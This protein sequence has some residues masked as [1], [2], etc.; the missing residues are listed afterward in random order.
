LYDIGH[1]HGPHKYSDLSVPIFKDTTL[2]LETQNTKLTPFCIK[3]DASFQAPDTICYEQ[4]V[5]PI[6]VD[7]GAA[8]KHTWHLK[9]N[10]QYEPIPSFN[11]PT[12]GL[13]RIKHT[14]EFKQCRDTASRLV[15]VM[16]EPKINIRDTI[17]CGQNNFNIDLTT[18]YGISYFLNNKKTTPIVNINKS[19]SYTFKIKT[20][21]CSVS[22][23]ASIKLVDFKI[24][25]PKQDSLVCFGTSYPIVFG[26]N[27]E[28]IFWD[29]QKN[30]KDTFW[31][32]DANVH[33]YQITYKFDKDCILD[34]NIKIDRKD[35]DE[36]FAPS[37][38]SPNGDQIND[39][40]RPY[41]LPSQKMVSFSVFDRWGSLVFES[42]QNITAWD[43]NFRNQPCSLGAY[44]F[45]VNYFDLKSTTT[46]TMFG[47]VMLMR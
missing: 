2:L 19:G 20:N 28:N 39:E 30:S 27:F 34:G 43:G 46:K 14:V 1:P 31:I 24:P 37:A 16:P 9:P 4:L 45:A 6:N 32:N 7:T 13:Q 26:N 8:V 44:T 36:L 33:N 3:L 25:K 38:F 5:T 40:F 11:F 15:F 18:K 29:K 10:Y 22:K 12:L 35:C 23:S 17:I 42:N 47:N 41:P 21:G